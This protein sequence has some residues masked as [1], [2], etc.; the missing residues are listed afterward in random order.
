MKKVLFAEDD[1]ED[2]EL[3]RM[4]AKEAGWRNAVTVFPNGETLLSY[5]EWPEAP[6]P[7]LILLGLR[8]VE[9][10]GVLS[11][12]RT[13]PVLSGVPLVV[14]CNGEEQFELFR[15]LGPGNV[16]CLL[17]PIIFQDF[18]RLAGELREKW[19]TRVE[20][21]ALLPDL[22]PL[23]APPRQVLLNGAGLNPPCRAN[24]GSG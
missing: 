20:G 22:R 13:R 24:G 10:I 16:E 1:D 17:K 6:M 15:R 7:A 8:G 4:A 9:G 3:F 5:L 12:L 18:V 23:A 2:R 14:L 21:S 19:L 11:W